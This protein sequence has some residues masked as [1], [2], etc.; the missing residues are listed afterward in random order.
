VVWVQRAEHTLGPPKS[1]DL[2]E[3]Q[4]WNDTVACAVCLVVEHSGRG[5]GVGMVW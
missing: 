2:W 5:A 4:A 1:Q 3:A